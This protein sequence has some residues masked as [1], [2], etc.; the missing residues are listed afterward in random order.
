M[1]TVNGPENKSRPPKIKCDDDKCVLPTMMNDSQWQRTPTT[2]TQKTNTIYEVLI[3]HCAA[4][5][6]IFFLSFFLVDF[7]THFLMYGKRHTR[8]HVPRHLIVILIK[9][10]LLLVYFIALFT[11]CSLQNFLYNKINKLPFYMAS[12]QV[13]T[14]C[15]THEQYCN[16]RH[17]R[18][19]AWLPLVQPNSTFNLRCRHLALV[20]P[21][22]N[23]HFD[24][25]VKCITVAHTAIG[26]VR[27]PIALP[28]GDCIG[29]VRHMH[30]CV[31]LST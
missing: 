2:A 13:S 18:F 1:N 4:I 15:N 3:F 17:F 11:E 27:T 10:S 20:A 21:M 12:V 5:A 22:Q 16:A 29:S 26:P 7:F 28:H 23:F 25:L 31:F 8:I 14:T 24:V 9:S 30:L 6:A 19:D